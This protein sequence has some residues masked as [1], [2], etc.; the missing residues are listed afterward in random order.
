[1]TTD[2]PIGEN[3]KNAK[4]PKLKTIDGGKTKP[5]GDNAEWRSP[6]GDYVIMAGAFIQQRHNRDGL[7]IDIPLCNFI[8]E[9]IEEVI[10]DDGL[11]DKAAYRIQGKRQNG[12]NLP[13]IEVAL[14][15]FALMNW[16]G[17][18]WGSRALIYSGATKRDNL[19]VAIVQY[20]TRNGDIPRRVIFT[21]TGWKRIDDNWHYSTGSGAVTATGLNANVQVDL[22]GGHMSKYTLPEPPKPEQLKTDIAATLDDLLNVCPSRPEIGAVLLAAVARAPLGECLPTDFAIFIHGATGWGKPTLA[23]IALAFF[24]EFDTMSFPANFTDSISDL[25]GK[26][27][28]LKD[29]L[30]IVDDHKRAVNA[31]ESSKLDAKTE[32]FVRNTGNQSGRGRRN[33]D[34][35]AKA[36]PYNRSLTIMT[37]EDLPRGQ[38]ILARLLVIELSPGDA[39]V[40]M[41]RSLEQAARDGALRRIM[42]TYIHWLAPRIGVLKEEFPKL[43]NGLTKDSSDRKLFSSHNRAHKMHANLVAA[44]RLFCA[45]LHATGAVEESTKERLTNA[46]EANISTAFQAQGDYQQNEDE[47]LRFQDLLRSVLNGGNG[48]IADRFRQ[49]P[50]TTVPHSWGWRK[51]SDGEQHPMGDCL[52]WFSHEGGKD[53]EVWLDQNLAYAAIQTLARKQG[54]V[55]LMQPHVL[56]RRFHDRGLLLAVDNQGNG[57]PKTTVKRIVSGSSKRVMVLRADWLVATP[58]DEKN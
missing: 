25:E 33:P 24:G 1:M 2:N 6:S 15:K 28:Q 7:L 53:C 47:V 49:E 22:G 27:H 39:D 57:R 10:Y 54:E 42:A 44:A 5:Q 3:I 8:A 29:G 26:A 41:M 55:F 40:T 12:A 16:S 13:A 17:E 38:S 51:N 14:P 11:S 43:V 23:A 45:F 18:L 37:G 32:N 58:N 56:W 31:V 19:R 30:Y 46:L 9:I 21:Y 50:P 4:P 35:T 48:H 36:A 52:G 20:S 34:M